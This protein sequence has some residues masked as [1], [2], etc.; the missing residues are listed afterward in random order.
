MRLH[1]NL[2]AN[3]YDPPSENEADQEM[4]PAS[5]MPWHLKPGKVLGSVKSIV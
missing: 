4:S 3:T 5:A 2:V 1:H